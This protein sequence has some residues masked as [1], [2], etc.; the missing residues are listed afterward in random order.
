MMKKTL[1][2]LLALLIA[3]S[4]SSQTNTFP[5]SGNVGIGTT[6]PSFTLHI[7][8]SANQ[9]VRL[10]STNGNWLDFESTNAPIGSRIWTIGHR[11]TT[12]MFGIGQRDGVSSY[13]MV[14]DQNGNLGIGNTSPEAPLS[15]QNS[16]G[17]KI[18]LYYNQAGNGDRYG[19]QVQP[20]ELRIHSRAA[21][22]NTGGIT[23]GKQSTS[24][25]TEH[26]RFTNEGNVG[27]GTTSPS[28]KLQIEGD[29]L[30]KSG[31]K[32]SWGG[33]Q[34]F[35]EGSMVSNKIAF[36]TNNLER[37]R[38]ADGGNVGI[39]TT[40][41][42]EKL[43]VDG[44][45]LAKKVRVS[46]NAADWPDYVFTNGYKLMGIGELERYI[47][48]NK[49]LPE[50]PSAEEVEEKGLDLGSMDATLLKKVEELTLY[51]IEQNKRLMDQN[52]RLKE[53]EK[54]NKTLEREIKTLRK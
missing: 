47:K 2:T 18:D 34:T 17:N 33:T 9:L 4:A 31:E 7:N 46:V 12:G 45:I 6:S 21:G 11:G 14:I 19:F 25:Y 38:V 39:G 52:E 24:T 10:T 1:Y 30:I 32:L 20:S 29:V 3:L 35:I 42:T 54:Q 5:A 51:L 36:F 49:H 23:F 8:S 16:V 53:L 28:A 26:V 50:V 22:D 44:N 27:I 15:F 48:Q 13:A 37:I 43:S 40:S 41:P